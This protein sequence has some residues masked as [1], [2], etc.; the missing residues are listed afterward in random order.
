MNILE[1]RRRTLGKGVYKKTVEGN[2]AIAQDSLAR[3]YPGITMQGWT[4]QPSTTGAQL[5]DID[6]FLELPLEPFAMYGNARTLVLNL[7]PN[8]QYTMSTDNDGSLGGDETE[9]NRSLYF[10]TVEDIEVNGVNTAVFKGHNITKTSDGEGKLKVMLFDRENANP[11]VNKE[12]WVMLN[13]G[14]TAKTY[15]EYTG[16]NPSPS[17]DYLQEIRNSGKYNE[18]TQRYE[19][20]ISLMTKNLLDI[21]DI[22]AE[23]PQTAIE[24]NIVQDIFISAQESGTVS[25]PIWRFQATYKDGTTKYL[26]DQN[27]INWTFPAT[28]ENPIVKIV[29]RGIF[30]TSGAY[31]NIQVEY[32]TRA[33][34]YVPHAKQTAKITSDRPVSKWDR[35]E[36]RDGVY[37][38]VYRTK[39]IND[40]AAEI[41]DNTTIWGTDKP[42]FSYELQN[43]NLNYSKNRI[44][45]GVGI[46]SKKYQPNAN[47]KSII[48]N[49]NHGD[50][51][52]TA[53]EHLHYAVQYETTEAEEFVPL[54]EEEQ[55]ALKELCT[56]YPTTVLSNDCGCNMSLTYKT[57]KSLEVT[58]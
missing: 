58:T 38:W 42:Y 55:Q 37:G 23:T 56:Y 16:G 20:M 30:I 33:T 40:L 25:K 45:S 7:K 14:N 3:M 21:P 39:F 13:K 29:F 48:I 50:T 18:E 47:T 8:T 49:C 11:I 31:K 28:K 57:K 12:K 44:I 34:S 6:E 15:E 22:T 24:C 17:P 41:P 35:L 46:G 9:K 43:T 10:T 32:G 36:R 2:P 51:L 19:Y 4:E 5:F 27:E 26:N 54:P 1:A 52:E 53:K